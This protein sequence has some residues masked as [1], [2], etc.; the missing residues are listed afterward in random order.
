M[1]PRFGVPLKCWLLHDLSSRIFFT[2]RRNGD[3][4]EAIEWYCKQDDTTFLTGRDRPW[5]QWIP[6]VVVAAEWYA[7][8]PESVG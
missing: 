7:A 6:L 5:P 2:M 4:V 1:I 8:H 3:S